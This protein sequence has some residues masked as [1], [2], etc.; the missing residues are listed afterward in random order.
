[1]NPRLAFALLSLFAVLGTSPPAGAPP[2]APRSDLIWWTTH[3]LEDVRPDD[4]P[5]AR[6]REGDRAADDGARGAEVAAARNEFE[7]FQLVL[8]AEGHPVEGVDVEMGD[9]VSTEGNA[10]IGRR[11]TTVYLERT[12]VLQKPSSV[13]GGTGE[14]PDPLVP[15]VDRYVGERRNA[16]PFDLPPGRNQPLWIDL[17]VPTGTPPG[18][19][20]GALRVSVEGRLRLS[21]PVTLEVW[22]FTLPSTSSLATSYGFS[23]PAALRAHRGSHPGE[24]DLFDLTR[25]YRVAA[26]RHRLSL[27][28]GSMVAP[29]ADFGDDTVRVDWSRHDQ[30]LAPFLDGT[31]FGADDPLPGARVT[32][33][34]LT[35]PPKLPE[36]RRILY[37][38]AWAEHYRRRGWLDRL[39]VY[40]A[41]EPSGPRGYAEVLHRGRLAR[42]ADPALQTL[43]TEQRAPAL[44]EVVDLWV[45][46]VPCIEPRP[47]AESFCEQTVPRAAYAPDEKRGARLWWYRS[48]LSHGCDTVGGEPFTGWPSLVIDSSPVGQRILPWLA[49]VFDVDG[50]LYYSTD[51]ADALG[52]DPWSEIR[53]HG[54]NGDGTLFYPGTPARI[55]GTTDVPIESL[56]LKRI[57]EGLEDYEYLKLL[58]RRG[59]GV[60]AREVARDL[61]P[62]TFRWNHDPEALYA[63][64]RRLARD[65][66]R[67]PER[68]TRPPA[69]PA[70]EGAS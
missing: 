55:G 69:E 48:C 64:R 26:L 37:W 36:P 41:D 10:E 39:F 7:P 20:R 66:I 29:P 44:A 47:G 50:E 25:R 16:F 24:I 34:D 51:E 53:A 61:A 8:R 21:V 63:S 14:W 6:A 43:V 33:I 60:E 70:A 31:V 22:P 19:Y 13:D 23:G 27:Y 49:Y 57:R 42:R 62:A 54:G 1:M 56:R 45:T 12:V 18:H 65:L 68:D 15:R 59:R 67:H 32:S 52:V 17:Y 46:P 40:L 4:P 3:A 38:R 9:L 2:A 35:D 11:H 28:G 5:A 30:E 58:A